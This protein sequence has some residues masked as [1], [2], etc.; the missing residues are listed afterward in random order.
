VPREEGGDTDNET[1]SFCF[2]YLQKGYDF[3]TFRGPEDH[4]AFSRFL[5]GIACQPWRDIKLASRRGRGYE[6]IHFF[7]TTKPQGLEDKD[8][9]AFRGNG[10]R[11]FIGFRERQTLYVVWIDMKGET[12]EH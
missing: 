6:K 5:V 3:A 2:K 10:I 4:T 9:I 12:Y 11:R 8:F 1:P 7:L